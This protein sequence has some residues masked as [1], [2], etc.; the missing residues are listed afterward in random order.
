M[1]PDRFARRA[2]APVL[3]ASL[4]GASASQPTFASCGAAS[5]TLTTD[6]FVQGAWDSPGF[7]LDLRA[8]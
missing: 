1:R 5:C 7:Y 6:R 8:E 3:L 2:S 4:V